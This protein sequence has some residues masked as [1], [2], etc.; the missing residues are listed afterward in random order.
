MCRESNTVLQWD[1][2]IP[3]FELGISIMMTKHRIMTSLVFVA[4]FASVLPAQDG[5]KVGMAS[6]KITPASPVRMAGYG[7]KEREQLSQGVAAD[8]FAKAVVLQDHSGNRALLITT[9]II[10]FKAG[11]SRAIYARIEEQTGITRNQILINSSHTHT[12]PVV[13]GDAGALQHWADQ[14][15][16]EKTVQYTRELRDKIV[17]LAVSAVSKMEPARLSWGV[18][19]ATFVMNRREFTERG[20]RLGVNP[21]GLVDR[22]VP[23]LKI[24]GINGKLRCVVFGAAC[25][26]TTLTG[27]HMQLSGDFAGYAQQYL[28]DQLDGVQAMF[29]QGCAGDANPFPRGEEAIARYHGKTLAGEVQRVI[30]SELQG[31]DGPIRTLLRSAEL[32]LQT[33]L[34]AQLFDQLNR[35]SGA[36]R[37]VAEKLRAMQEAGEEIPAKFSTEIALWQLGDDLTLVALP[38]EVVVD[39]VKLVEDRLGPRKLW[40]TAYNHDVF[41]YLPSARVLREGGYETRG[42]YSGGVGIFS[43]DAESVVVDAVTR[44]ATQ[45]GR[46]MPLSGNSD[47]PSN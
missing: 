4:A 14:T 47:D 6:V 18:G 13:N 45:S 42:I 35:A 20:V 7:N 8:L 32:P 9:D 41:G 43:P 1:S 38:A 17:G 46:A 16:I 31:V 22:S 28:E 26:N 10:G 12:G 3:Q 24:E 2:L 39:Y 37:G 30:Q 19:V 36:T 40:V 23:I 25:H 21:R 44:L 27:K 34:S 5:W 11:D 33:N 15:H 29:V